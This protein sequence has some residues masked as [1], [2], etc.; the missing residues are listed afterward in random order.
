MNPHP[1]ATCLALA[2]PALALIS[3]SASKP[4]GSRMPVAAAAAT[5]A[6]RQTAEA[7][8]NEVNAFRAAKGEEKM[9]RHAG[10]DRLAQGHSE[11][12]R[13]NRG[14]FGLDGKNV[15]HDGFDSRF[16]IAREKYGIIGMQENVAAAPPGTSIISAWKKSSIHEKVMRAQWDC[17]GMGVVIDKDGYIFAT[18]IFG[19]PASSHLML[20]ERFG[21]F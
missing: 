21:G 16:V 9:K 3:C 11:F 1:I 2:L 18:Q 15:S 4:A 20:Q 19:N 5:P 7:L 10:L 8:F 17:S 12:M 14:H 13:R 6:E